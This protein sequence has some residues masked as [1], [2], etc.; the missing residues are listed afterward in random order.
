MQTSSR[1]LDQRIGR[2]LSAF[3]LI[4]GSSALDRLANGGRAIRVASH[5][6]LHDRKIVALVRIFGMLFRNSLLGLISWRSCYKPRCSRS[7]SLDG[8]KI[9]P[10]VASRGRRP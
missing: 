9:E 2:F 7:F 6:H 8:E 4:H 10:A 5:A 3:N 1:Q